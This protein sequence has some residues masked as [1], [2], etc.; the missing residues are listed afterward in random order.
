MLY[1]A[2]SLSFTAG[3]IIVLYLL[4]HAQPVFGQTLNEVVFD[5]ILGE[6]GLSHH[7]LPVILFFEAALLFVWCWVT[8]HTPMTFGLRASP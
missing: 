6:T 4:W 2:V 8:L 3:G 5:S 1:M 7:W